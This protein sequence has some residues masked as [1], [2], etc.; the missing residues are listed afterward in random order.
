MSNFSS[1]REHTDPYSGAP[2]PKYEHS[3]PERLQPQG[4]Y[5]HTHRCADLTK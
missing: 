3:E 5:H 1:A 2:D 4:D